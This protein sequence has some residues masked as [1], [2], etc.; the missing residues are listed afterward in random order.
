MKLPARL[1][2]STAQKKAD[3]LQTDLSA[4]RADL[5]GLAQAVEASR[6]STSAAMA[7]L[8]GAMQ[9]RPFEFDVQRDGEGFIVRVV[10]RPL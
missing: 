10:A 5:T 4:I 1:L 8:S 7:R 2:P 6:E 9:K 3:P